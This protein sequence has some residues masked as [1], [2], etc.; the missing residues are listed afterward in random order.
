MS[1]VWVQT[2]W[3]AVRHL[4]LDYNQRRT[5]CGKKVHRPA[6]HP[7]IMLYR[8]CNHCIAASKILEKESE[9]GSTD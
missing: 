2:T 6:S 5:L 7:R 8:P 1:W 3:S 4:A 9:N